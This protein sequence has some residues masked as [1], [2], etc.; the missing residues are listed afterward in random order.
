MFLFY[1]FKCLLHFKKI[2]VHNCDDGW[3]AGQH[4][5]LRVFFSNRVLESHLPT[6]L[7]TPP[8]HSCLLSPGLL[9]AARTNGDWTRAL[10]NYTRKEQERLQTDEKH[11]GGPSTLVQVVLDGPYGES[12]VDLGRYES[13]LLSP[14][15]RVSHSLSVCL[16]T[17]SAGVSSSGVVRESEQGELSSFG[18]Y[19]LLVTFLAKNGCG[20]SS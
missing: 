2:R 8:S 1:S 14:A 15:C 10:N 5:R 16:T 4:V 13:T 12:S 19:D 17:S 18:A 7:S 9:L 20:M 11:E 6:I 3:L